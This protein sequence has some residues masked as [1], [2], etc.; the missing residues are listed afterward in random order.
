[1]KPFKTYE[2][3][4]EILKNRFLQIESETWLREKLKNISYYNLING[5]SKIFIKKDGTYSQN[6]TEKHIYALYL[7]D[8]NLSNALQKNILLAESRIVPV[9]YT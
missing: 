1:M 8:K 7:F 6:V 2:E 3:Q 5:Y 9:N 4:I